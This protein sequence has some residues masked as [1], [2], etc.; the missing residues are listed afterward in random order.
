[1]N[2]IELKEII[3]KIKDGFN[4]HRFGESGV[5]KEYM[6]RLAKLNYQRMDQVVDELI[7][8][9]SREVPPISLLLQRYKG[10]GKNN[11]RMEIRN[12]KYC[13]TCHDRGFVLL[14]EY[15]HVGLDE[16]GKTMDLPYQFVYYCPYC[17]VGTQ[18][19][20]DGQQCREKSSYRIPAITEVLP[21]DVLNNMRK[22]NLKKKRQNE[23]S[24]D[25]RK[26]RDLRSVTAN[27]V[28]EVPEVSHYSDGIYKRLESDK[29]A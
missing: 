28:K 17:A 8:E 23:Q 20:Y 11:A 14:T 26:S 19:N 5:T 16:Y 4:Y 24:R 29:D 12:S 2:D 15:V 10:L 3:N 21:E 7:E 22:E 18:Y 25:E 6:K 27:I 9:N 13:A 1:M